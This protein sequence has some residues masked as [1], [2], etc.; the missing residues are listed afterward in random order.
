MKRDPRDIHELMSS[1]MAGNISDTEAL[2]LK[3]LIATDP[4]VLEAW[5]QFKEKFLPE[6]VHN[7]FLR[8]EDIPWLPAE[9]ITKKVSR[10]QIQHILLYVSLIAAVLTGIIAGGYLFYNRR[11]QVAAVTEH[12]TNSNNISL[13]LANGKTIDLSK[14]QD[15]IQLAGARLNNN[16]KA[17]SYA[18]AD[19]N[20]NTADAAAISKLTVPIG[21]DYKI[22]LPDGSEI[23][24]NSGS[25][26]L[27]SLSLKGPSRE[28]TLSGEAFIKVAPQ[29]HRPF[30]VHTPHGTV[31]VLG[32]SFNVNTYDP[33]VV[34]VALVEGAVRF[35]AGNEEVAI[36]PDNEVIYTVN[37]GMQVQPFD[38]DEILGWRNGK[39]YFSDATLQEIVN[40]LPRWYGTN[41]LIDNPDLARE[42]FA[43][44]MDRNKPITA[45]LDNLGNTRK[46][47]YHYDNE[48][49]LH[50]Q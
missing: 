9:V 48:G 1:W 7:D 17:L 27:F 38:E 18:L 25:R 45:F 19:D 43:G 44:M 4:E 8:Y 23:W 46:I 29:A 14:A 39:Y 40:V 3:Q 34:K 15:N 10:K 28:I 24:L 37:K 35:K 13:Q 30:L 49:V 47:R 42:H 32:T 6:D 16:G 12:P 41:V 33:G 21:K 31:E 50:L 20:S 22:V 5:E 26:L 2:Y 11:V 36:K